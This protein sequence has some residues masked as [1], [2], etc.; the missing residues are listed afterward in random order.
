MGISI[1]CQSTLL[2]CQYIAYD[3]SIDFNSFY[4]S[5][6]TY[7]VVWFISVQSW[8]V[9]LNKCDLTGGKVLS[10]YRVNFRLMFYFW[11]SLLCQYLLMHLCTFALNCLSDGNNESSIDFYRYDPF[12]H[13]V[14]R[15]LLHFSHLIY[16]IILKLMYRK[17]L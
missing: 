15:L 1:I 14:K 12:H 9:S 8:I 6:D 4:Q 10:E 2:P 16:T 5:H 13:Q 11:F 3:L 17:T 7:H